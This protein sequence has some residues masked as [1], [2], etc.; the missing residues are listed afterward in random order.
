VSRRDD[1]KLLSIVM[2]FIKPVPFLNDALASIVAQR[3]GEVELVVIA[4]HEPGEDVGISPELMSG[5]DQLI[6]EPDG[7]PWEAANKGWRAARGR[8]V[9]YCMA[10]DWLPEGSLKRTLQFLRGEPTATLLSGGMS[11]MA[12]DGPGG[13]RTIRSVA[14]QELTLNRVLDDVCSPAVIFRRDLLDELGGFDDRFAYAHDREFMLRA[15][16]RKVPHAR[17]PHESYRMR[18]HD[19]S[20]TNSGDRTVKLAYWCDH[21]GFAD[22][23]L[24]A[25][26]LDRDDRRKLSRWRD[27]ELVKFH[28]LRRLTAPNA[29]PLAARISLYHAGAALA[30]LVRRKAAQRIGAGHRRS[31]QP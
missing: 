17:L 22:A 12:A 29:R 14:A 23:M 9:Q 25:G 31:G 18:V 10:D 2:Y 6:I 1:G 24:A 8:W 4:G 30:R 3:T 15:W 11:F 5:I 26:E 13:L 19:L 16:Q 20:R 21:V 27:E 7:G 28:I